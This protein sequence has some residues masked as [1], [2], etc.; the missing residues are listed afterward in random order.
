MNI[1]AR[2]RAEFRAILHGDT[3]MGQSVGSTVIDFTEDSGMEN[4]EGDLDA[5]S[6]V[7]IVDW[8]HMYRICIVLAYYVMWSKRHWRPQKL[9]ISRRWSHYEIDPVS[10]CG[11]LSEPL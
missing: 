2:Q 6:D 3:N 10:I 1:K 8:E 7:E 9:G 5:G 11:R 4:P